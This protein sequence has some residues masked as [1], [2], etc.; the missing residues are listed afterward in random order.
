MT[1]VAAK[2]KRTVADIST[3]GAIA[4]EDD[5]LARFFVSTPAFA[6]LRDG[7]RQIVIGRKGAGKSALYLA[8]IHGAKTS[9]DRM[10]NAVGLTFGDY[11]WA[12][13]YK[14]AREGTDRHER[15]TAA[16]EFLALLEIAKSVLAD[17]EHRTRKYSKSAREALD[18]VESFLKSNY[19][20][21]QFDFKKTFP[22]G[23]FNL[24]AFK[25]QPTIF[26]NSVG[27]A[28]IT[29]SGSLGETVARLNEWLRNALVE[30][31]TETPE[32]MVLFD[33]LD[34][35]FDPAANDYVDRVIGLLLAVRRLAKFMR[36]AA[37]EHKVIAFLR[38]DVYDSLHFGDK[39]K[40]T[41][42]NVSTL[43]WNDDLGPPYHDTSLKQLLDH[44]VRVQ[45]GL[46]ASEPDPWTKAFDP[47][48]T[49]GTQHKFHHMTFRGHRRPRDLIKFA[50][51]ALLA[52]KH[53]IAHGDDRLLIINE[54][55]N[56]ARR[57]Y[58][59]YLI[60]ELDDE[61]APVV[62]NWQDYLEL[63]RRIGVTRWTREA[64]SQALE[65]LGP[66]LGLAKTLDEI[67]AMFYRYSIVGF[68]RIG[69]GGTG[70]G[71]YEHFR[72]MDESIRFDAKSPSFLVHRGLREALE[73]L[74]QK[75]ARDEL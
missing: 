48:L 14:Y 73:L 55:I 12:V 75:D 23:S 10:Y 46:P 1:G 51:E 41:D 33:E 31:G 50:N 63:L 57:P 9:L 2:T 45:L 52:A 74:E 42:A 21:V 26:G 6:D 18:G 40:M 24:Q 22:T 68:Q 38:S 20:T 60:K 15:F 36:D 69:R 72:Y 19:G 49:K 28:D 70:A 16:W 17:P 35:G 47:Q 71:Y 61:I 59:Q 65:A 62:P 66:S 4:A 32:A 56:Q 67:L 64:L 3:F 39:N 5:D 58:S 11:P 53:R 43:F 13:H 37:L 30:A 7:R 29:R 34:A 44:R 54:D 8:L 25:V 27:G